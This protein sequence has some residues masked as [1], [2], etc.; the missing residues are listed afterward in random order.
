M[1]S[2]SDTLRALKV[3]RGIAPATTLAR[4]AVEFAL[5]VGLRSERHQAAFS[6]SG[7]E[8]GEVQTRL[9]L[10]ALEKK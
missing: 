5:A 4:S 7:R 6:V 3:V 10:F 8:G 1:V 9:A 2:V